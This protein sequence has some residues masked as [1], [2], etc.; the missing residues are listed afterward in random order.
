VTGDLVTHDASCRLLAAVSGCVVVAVDYRL[1]PEHPY[2]AAI[3]DAMAAYAWVHRNAGEL[4]I[5]PGRIGVMGDSAGGNMAA[6]LSLLTRE[7]GTRE[8][9]GRGSAGPAAADPLRA[10]P[11]VPPPV[12][13]C[14]VYPVVKAR[15]GP[16]AIDGPLADGFFLTVDGMDAYRAAY[17]PDESVWEDA[18]VSPLLVG[19]LGDLPPAVVVTAGFDPLRYDGDAY[20]HRLADAGVEVEHRHYPDQVHGFFGM[21]ILDDSLALSTEV[22]EVMGRLMHRGSRP[23][24]G[25]EG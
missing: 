3:D 15:L 10:G 23:D 20:A 13:Q 4:G 8:G 24:A 22:C 11:P 9:S 7:G 6:V 14:L 16:E 12:A 2:P 21:G 25:R 18:A 17:V 19:D 1:A 5:E